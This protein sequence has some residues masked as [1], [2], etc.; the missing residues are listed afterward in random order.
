MSRHTPGKR[1]QQLT[2]NE[3]G[4]RPS[5]QGCNA[6]DGQLCRSRAM[7]EEKRA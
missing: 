7:A 6:S 3:L 2:E 5:L 4:I 1:L